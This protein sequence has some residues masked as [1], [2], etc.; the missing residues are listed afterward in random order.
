MIC[1]RATS[2]SLSPGRR[3]NVKTGEELICSQVTYSLNR[4]AC[5]GTNM[6]LSRLRRSANPS[7]EYQVSKVRQSPHLSPSPGNKDKDI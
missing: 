4:A 2:Y 3:E 1:K 7:R 6:N 5:P